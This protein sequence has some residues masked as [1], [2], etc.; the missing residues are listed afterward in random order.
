[1]I[2][3]LKRILCFFGFHDYVKTPV[4]VYLYIQPSPCWT[5]MDQ[6]KRCGEYKR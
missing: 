4:L 1:M 2:K 5:V 6:C 3:S